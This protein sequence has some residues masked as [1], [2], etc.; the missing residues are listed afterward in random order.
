VTNLAAASEPNRPAIGQSI[1]LVMP[2]NTPPA[3]R[4]PAP[5]VSIA[6][7]GKGAISINARP[8]KI[9]EPLEPIV[10]DLAMTGMT[11]STTPLDP[12]CAAQSRH[13]IVLYPHTGNSDVILLKLKQIFALNPM[14]Y[15]LSIR[16]IVTLCL[17]HLLRK[18][19]LKSID[20]GHKLNKVF[21]DVFG[22]ELT[23]K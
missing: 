18:D 12:S 1:P 2:Y 20:S 21:A 22:V 16:R 14:S 10:P 23:A 11:S 13:P 3:Y 17:R 19:P 7:T 15:I 9:S 8:S 5:T 4:S 6:L